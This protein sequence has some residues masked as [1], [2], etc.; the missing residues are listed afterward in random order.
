[1]ITLYSI[2]EILEYNNGIENQHSRSVI[3]LEIVA[4]EWNSYSNWFIIIT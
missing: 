1:M 4:K 3:Y 2:V